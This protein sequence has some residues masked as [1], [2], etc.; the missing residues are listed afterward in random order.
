MDDVDRAQEINEA[1]LEESLARHRRTRPPLYPPPL[2]GEAPSPSGGGLGRGK[3]CL[4][5]GEE[6]PAKRWAAMPGCP[7]C[8]DCQTLHENW[9]PL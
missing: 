2:G 9:R 3:M 7:R 8:I 1:H 5:C 6:I 4:D